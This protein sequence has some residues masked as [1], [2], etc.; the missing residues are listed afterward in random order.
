MEHTTAQDTQAPAG[1]DYDFD[2]EE[3]VDRADVCIKSSAG[4]PTGLV[5]TLASPT[6]PQRKAWEF[7]AQ[8][9]KRAAIK[10]SGSVITSSAED[11]Y[12]DDAERLAVCTL[13][14]NSRTPFSRAAALA[15]YADSRRLHIRQQVRTAL[16]D[17]DLFT[18]SSAQ[19]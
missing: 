18:R 10:K 15:V 19:R 5:I 4:T 3:V 12:A 11:D 16:D 6:H 7:A 13:G 14:W 9:R 2:S 8:N 17:L 1:P